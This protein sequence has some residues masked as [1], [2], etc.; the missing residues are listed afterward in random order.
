MGLEAA[1]SRTEQ[2][3]VE[4]VPPRQQLLELVEADVLGATDARAE[5]LAR[6]LARAA[7]EQHEAEEADDGDRA[8]EEQEDEECHAHLPAAP[9]PPHRA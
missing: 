7:R 1:V 3:L 5:H 2:P 6:T 9:S 8:D 4:V